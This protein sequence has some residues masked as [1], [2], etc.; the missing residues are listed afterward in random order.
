MTAGWFLYVSDFEDSHAYSSEHFWW[1]PCAEDYFVWLTYRPTIQW[2]K[3]CGDKGCSPFP[4]KHPFCQVCLFLLYVC[5][6]RPIASLLVFASVTWRADGGTRLSQ[7]KNIS[8]LAQFSH[9]QLPTHTR[10]KRAKQIYRA[11]QSSHAIFFLFPLPFCQIYALFVTPLLS[12]LLLPDPSGQLGEDWAIWS[13]KRKCPQDPKSD[14]EKLPFVIILE[15]I[16]KKYY[17][18]DVRF[19]FWISIVS[20]PHDCDRQIFVWANWSC[21]SYLSV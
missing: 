19:Q 14:R 4:K 8:P 13:M 7:K 21:S 10:A 11:G 12:L 1:L 15:I 16:W 17:D 20:P 18:Y 6:H 2:R 3:I 9:T 5:R